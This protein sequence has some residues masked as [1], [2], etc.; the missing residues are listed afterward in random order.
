[1]I[2]CQ[3]PAVR[4]IS[5]A[6]SDAQSRQ[7]RDQRTAQETGPVSSK[8]RGRI[9]HISADGSNRCP[10]CDCVL[11]APKLIIAYRIAKVLG[12]AQSPRRLVIRMWRR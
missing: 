11:G 12:K 10:K 6:R 8:E 1:M 5:A 3:T 2:R 9:G 7:Q 4:R